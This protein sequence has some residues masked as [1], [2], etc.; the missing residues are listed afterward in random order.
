MDL[1]RNY[2]CY[3]RWNWW[4]PEGVFRGS[5]RD[6]FIPFMEAENLFKT[7]YGD[8]IPRRDWYWWSEVQDQ[9]DDGWQKYCR[10]PYGTLY[11]GEGLERK[12]LEC[13]KETLHSRGRCSR[14]T[15]LKNLN[16]RWD[17]WCE[18]GTGFYCLIMRTPMNLRRVIV[19][20][21]GKCIVYTMKCG[22]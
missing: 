15:L 8:L 4:W 3:L 1:R 12:F 14:N 10:E 21:G 20:G 6:T 18:K 16:T 11:F 9:A 2:N 7:K 13:W 5:L 17:I 19:Y 22:R